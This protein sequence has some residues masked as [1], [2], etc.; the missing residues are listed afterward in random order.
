M[1]DQFC[2]FLGGTVILSMVEKPV[3]SPLK[4]FDYG[5]GEIR[6]W[7]NMSTVL[8]CQVYLAGSKLGSINM[9]SSL[10]PLAA[11]Q[12][13]HIETAKKVQW[14]SDTHAGVSLTHG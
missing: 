11:V 3:K 7:L 2:F 4:V 6:V 1:V 13:G 9:G 10:K 14:S 12:Y 5:L 8:T